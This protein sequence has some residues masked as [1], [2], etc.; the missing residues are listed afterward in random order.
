[1]DQIASQIEYSKGTLY[2]HFSCKEE[3]LAAI[4][5]ESDAIRSSFFDRAARFAG[6]A[7]ERLTCL[8]YAYELY[9]V[10]YP[11]HFNCERIIESPE[12]QQKISPKR[13]SSAKSQDQHCFQVMYEMIADAH[14]E[15]NLQIG[16]TMSPEKLCFNLWA[17]TSGAFS[18]LAA[19][20]ELPGV[21]SEELLLSV[22]HHIWL[23]LDG[24][25]WRPLSTEFDY[26]T[27]ITRSRTEIFSEP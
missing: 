3:V 27:V 23:A 20:F 21:S 13:R 10:K 12:V 17:T 25:Q 2:Q 22:R 5:A 16:S 14:R 6:C 8:G 26:N 7:R 1:M 18:K 24:Y 9:F 11:N 15:G 19:N 4:D